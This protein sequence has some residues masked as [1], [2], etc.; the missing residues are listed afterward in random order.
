MPK[1]NLLFTKTAIGCYVSLCATILAVSPNIESL[2]IR[3]KSDTDKAVLRD[4]FAI[5]IGTIGAV[6]TLIGRYQAGGTYT[7]K[8]LPGQDEIPTI[9]PLQ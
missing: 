9:P 7:P 5:V 4:Y 3:G 8:Y 1:R 6:G 2:I